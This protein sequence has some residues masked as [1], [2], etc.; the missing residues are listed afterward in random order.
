MACAE[1]ERNSGELS[2]TQRSLYDAKGFWLPHSA[3]WQREPEP[4]FAAETRPALDG[5][6]GRGRFRPLAGYLLKKEASEDDQSQ[7]IF[8]LEQHGNVSGFFDLG[9]SCW[10]HESD[11]EPPSKKN[12]PL[13]EPKH[14]VGILQ[15]EN[16]YLGQ[17]ALAA[18]DLP[19]R[20][21]LAEQNSL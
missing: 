21:T 8:A 9:V 1:T 17:E 18:F 6:Q 3:L 7:D 11:A 5:G 19:H 10:A 15:V 2:K 20:G 13:D 12:A 16:T 14:R 4:Y